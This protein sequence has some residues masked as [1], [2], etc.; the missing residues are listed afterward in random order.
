MRCRPN[1]M[2]DMTGQFSIPTQRDCMSAS[3]SKN[4]L[5]YKYRVTRQE[6][7]HVELT[8]NNFGEVTKKTGLQK[9]NVASI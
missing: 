8:S 5:W 9:L 6:I 3:T 2:L 1:K 4:M 7:V